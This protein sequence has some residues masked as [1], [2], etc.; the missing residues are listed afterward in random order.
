MSV[1]ASHLLIKHAGSRNP[2]SRRTNASTSGTTKE[3]AVAELTSIR[4]QLRA[5]TV[6]FADAAT[7]RSDCSSYRNG[8]DLGDFTRGQMQK[9]FEDAA[10]GL[11]VGEMS[12]IVD[13]DS[14][15]HLVL[16]TA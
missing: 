11:A 7:R 14:G 5:G 13:T 8:G 9:P 6:Q 15:V 10:F 2:V 4:D 12:D 1:R 3:A 16:R